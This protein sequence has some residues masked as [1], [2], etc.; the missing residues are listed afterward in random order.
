MAA[1]P[2]PVVHGASPMAAL[3]FIWEFYQ[4]YFF[5]VREV[6]RKE[7]IQGVR[8]KEQRRVFL[9]GLMQKPWGKPQV[10]SR[11]V[12]GD[13]SGGGLRERAHHLVLGP[14]RTFFRCALAFIKTRPPLITKP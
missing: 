12:K 13:D 7:M 10:S 6:F 3:E 11:T 2:F 1:A 5:K 14:C 9:K 8:S 4:T